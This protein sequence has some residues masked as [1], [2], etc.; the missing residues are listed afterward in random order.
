MVAVSQSLPHLFALARIA[1]FNSSIGLM[2]R[3]LGYT[4]DEMVSHGFRS[5][6]S[7]LAPAGVQRRHQLDS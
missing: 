5:M 3:R 1:Q 7:K 4:G 6:A 2:L